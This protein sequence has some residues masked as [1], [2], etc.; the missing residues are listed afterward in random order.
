M[1]IAV[2]NEF[3]KLFLVHED[4]EL[5]LVTALVL[6]VVTE[7]RRQ[8]LVE[9]HASEARLDEVRLPVRRHHAAADL[10]LDGELMLLVR[11]QCLGNARDDLA[12]TERARLEDRQVVGAEHHV[13]RRHDNGLA[14][15]RREDVV[16]GEHEDARLRLRLRRE[17]QM[18]G[19]LVAIEVGVVRRAGERMELERA[20]LGEHR[21]ERL[22][23]EAMERRGTV[24]EHRMLLDDVLEHIPDLGACALDHAFRG[25]DVMRGV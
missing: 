16:G 14:V 18:D 17:R 9:D 23:A 2:G 4:A 20:A 12:L 15:L 10:R 22:D 1:V 25:L 7:L 24:Q 13:L 19:H 6:M 8:D 21:L 5:P 11:E 3:A